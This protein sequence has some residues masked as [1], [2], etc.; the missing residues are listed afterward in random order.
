MTEKL[1]V[2]VPRLH[3]GLGNRIRMVLSAQDLA[4]S[5]GRGFEYVWP[6]G[7]PFGAELTELWDVDTRQSSLMRSRLRS[8]GHPYRDASASW[9]ADAADDAIWQVRASQPVVVD[10]RIDTWHERL[11]ALRPAPEVAAR[12]TALFDAHL[13]GAPYLGVMVR[14][15]VVSHE[16][17][18]RESPMEWYLDRVSD[19]RQQHPELPLFVS[20]DTVEAHDRVVASF[21]KVHSVRDKGAYNSAPALRAAVVDL[22]LLAGA[23]HILGPHY[24]SFPELA[25]YLAGPSVALETSMSAADSAFERAAPHTHVTDPT[26]PSL[27]IS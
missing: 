22:Y 27:R 20:A 13:R 3:H 21:P 7:E 9:V 5:V 26:R 14:S 18:L 12:I 16:N 23:T 10:G 6:T 1:V 25:Q 17:T 2:A 19:I 24:S 11:R 8:L 15:H 4:E